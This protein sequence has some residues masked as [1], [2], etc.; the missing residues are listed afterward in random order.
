ML[1]KTLLVC[2]A[3]IVSILL[4]FGY[5]HFLKFETY[6]VN[7]T[8]EINDS[9]YQITDI[10]HFPFRNKDSFGETVELNMP[11]YFEAN[12][13]SFD[14]QLRLG[15]VDHFFSFPYN[16]DNSNITNSG[17]FTGDQ[18]DLDMDTMTITINSSQYQVQQ[19]EMSN[20]TDDMNEMKVTFT[21][22]LDQK[23]NTL[24][25]VRLEI[26]NSGFTMQNLDSREGKHFML[27][28]IYSNKYQSLHP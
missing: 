19:M 15:K 2:L 17:T 8:I 24:N 1:K 20:M 25:A 10:G 7:K 28:P 13:I 6:S 11:W 16:K 14:W 3:V 23:I 26:G 12:W 18:S 5:H 9:S 22:E 4:V 27:S 21:V